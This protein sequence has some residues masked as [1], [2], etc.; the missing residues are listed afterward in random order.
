[1]TALRS[2]NFATPDCHESDTRVPFEGMVFYRDYEFYCPPYGA[3]KGGG[4]GDA[5]LGIDQFCQ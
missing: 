1:M 3:T 5:M 4:L 2:A